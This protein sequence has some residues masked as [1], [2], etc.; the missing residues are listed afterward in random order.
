VEHDPVRANQNYQRAVEIA[1][2]PCSVVFTTS[3]SGRWAE[4]RIETAE[5]LA[6]MFEEAGIPFENDLEDAQQFFSAAT[7]DDGVLDL[8]EWGWQG[9]PGFDY[10]VVFHDIF[11]PDGP[12]PKGSNYYRW[13][14][15]DSSVIDDSTRRF[16]EVRDAMN[17][18][19]DEREL[20]E[21]I[22][23][24]E[25]ILFENMVLIP[26]YARPDTAAVW[27]DRIAR[28]K[29]NPTSAGFTWNIEEW[30]R[31]DLVG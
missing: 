19:V 5:L 6:P 13:G 16:A 21:L 18:T 10:L 14:T 8:A 11:D 4:P 23:E 17:A 31:A 30:Y 29:H 24:A 26:L 1:G 12:P 2:K 20:T 3:R 27:A 28:F 15:E 25:S 7:F 22:S 9:S